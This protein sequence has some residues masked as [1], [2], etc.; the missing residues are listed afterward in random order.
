MEG[1]REPWRK[2]EQ[3]RD[4]VRLC[5][6][7]PYGAG[8]GSRLDSRGSDRRHRPETDPPRTSGCQPSLREADTAGGFAKSG[9]Q[10]SSWL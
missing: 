4:I 8:M 3:E 1:T 7:D 5:L 6:E 9:K 2:C 10:A